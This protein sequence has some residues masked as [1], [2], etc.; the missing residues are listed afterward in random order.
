MATDEGLTSEFPWLR[1]DAQGILG[2]ARPRTTKALLGK[3]Q[4]WV[5]LFRDWLQAKQPDYLAGLDYLSK[6]G[7]DAKSATE[8][9]AS[10]YQEFYGVAGRMKDVARKDVAAARQRYPWAPANVRSLLGTAR[11]KTFADLVEDGTAGSWYP[12]F[13]AWL[14]DRKP[15][16]GADGWLDWLG[17]QESESATWLARLDAMV[18]R[19]ADEIE[20]LKG[21]LRERHGNRAER[22]VRQVGEAAKDA[23]RKVG[24]AVG[25]AQQKLG[26]VAEKVANTQIGYDVA[27]EFR[28]GAQAAKKSAPAAKKTAPAAAKSVPAATAAPAAKQAP[29]VPPRPSAA[30]GVRAQLRLAWPL[31]QS[32]PAYSAAVDWLGQ[33]FSGYGGAL[34]DVAA[35]VRAYKQLIDGDVEYVGQQ[36]QVLAEHAG[37]SDDAALYA[38]LSTTRGAVYRLAWNVDLGFQSYFGGWPHEQLWRVAQTIEAAGSGQLRFAAGRALYGLA[39]DVQSVYEQAVGLLD[40]TKRVVD[41]RIHGYAIDDGAVPWDTHQVVQARTELSGLIALAAE[42]AG[43]EPAAEADGST[44]DEAAV[45]AFGMPCQNLLTVG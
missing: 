25:Q 43:Q 16:E 15:F 19:F 32:G 5:D 34:A 30:E 45:T 44:A 2:D 24:Q 27:G 29:A 28:Q 41:A 35:S 6:S 14:V 4:L 40:T 1:R 21:A 31:L 18:T 13:R 3:S 11:P 12:V 33:R 17:R 9:L 36:M 38:L 10:A 23:P 22:A 20:L 37:G 7:A 42:W 39:T 8:R 26:E